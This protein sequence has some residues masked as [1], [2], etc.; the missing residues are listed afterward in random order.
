MTTAAV[1]PRAVVAAYVEAVA[2]GDL[3]TIVASFAEDATW[4][5]PGTS[6]PF[7]RVWQGRDAIV[8]DFLV[9][10]GALFAPGT[11]PEVV[12]TNL[13]ADGDQVVVEW[14][15]TGTTL[16]GHRYDN[17]CIGVFTIRDGKIVSVR[18]YADTLH[19]AQ[20]LFAE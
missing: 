8:N 10:A 19:V 2:K 5:Y 16:H 1:A 7:S 6:L 12:L 3:D 15:S 17:R 14:T 18:E 20:T 4:T 13:V 11:A 9:G